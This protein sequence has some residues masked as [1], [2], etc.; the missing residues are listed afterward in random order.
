V[1][2]ELVGIEGTTR[3]EL[4]AIANTAGF[5]SK[6]VRGGN[7]LVGTATGFTA[8]VVGKVLGGVGAAVGGIGKAL[9]GP[10]GKVVGHSVGV[11]GAYEG[12]AAEPG[13]VLESTAK[14]AAAGAVM[15][16]AQNIAS[17]ALRVMFRTPV[18]AL[19]ASEKEAMGALKKWA[20][21]NNL[22]AERGETAMA[23][24]KRVVDTWIRAGLPGAPAMPARKLVGY[25]MRGGADATGFSLIDQQFREDLIDAAWNGDA[26]KWESVVTKFAG[27]F[28]GAAA[29]H[30]PLSSIVPWQRRQKFSDARKADAIPEAESTVVDKPTPERPQGERPVDAEFS[31]QPSDP[32]RLPA[33]K[34]TRPESF[35]REA[36]DAMAKE[37]AAR[38]EQLF[39]G[40]S[41]RETQSRWEASLGQS[42]DNVISLGWKPSEKSVRP[43]PA[44]DQGPQKVKVELAQSGHSFTIEGESAKPSPA[45]RESLGLPASMPAR[46]MVEAV[47]KSSLQSALNTKAML[48]GQEISVGVKGTPGKGDAP[49][50][51][52]RV[53]MGEIQESPLVPE[54]KWEKVEQAPARGKDA[55]EPDQAQAAGELRAVAATSE[56]LQPADRSLLNAAVDVLDTVAAR[57]DQSVA[58][59]MAAMPKIVEAIKSGEPGAVKALAE[60]LTTKVPEQALAD[61]KTTAGL[62]WEKRGFGIDMGQKKTVRRVDGGGDFTYGASEPVAGESFGTF[63]VHRQR[64]ASR[65][66][67]QWSVTHLPTGLAAGKFAKKADAKK[68]AEMLEFEIEKRGIGEKARSDDPNTAGEALIDAAASVR[69]RMEE[70][71][72]VDAE[73]VAQ[74]AR[75]AVEAVE[76]GGSVVRRL[77]E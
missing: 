22:F 63:G 58:E 75:A 42:L 55:I 13:T 6:V 40:E 35:T 62:K 25:A 41:A 32:L 30:V 45:L 48:P 9:F 38:W 51:M 71:G 31:V 70:G 4:D 10:A 54:P 16:F 18:N 2:P 59:T 27:N 34:E 56:T 61:M 19:G 12:I 49:P 65:R 14:G 23:F 66:G 69:Q 20:T 28:L 76:T 60:S 8:G 29:L 53:V 15:G 1:L 24:D 72:F 73:T 68:Y 39:T 7:E 47:E 36:N 77:W 52:R 37:Y 3:E 21:E 67:E 50:V 74:A 64:D 46:D 43:R 44:G 33:P 5:A 17:A 57:N 26:S 11:F